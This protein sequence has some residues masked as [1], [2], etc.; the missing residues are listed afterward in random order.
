M[1]NIVFN[2]LF[3]SLSH[4]ILC[5]LFT[6]FSM[7]PFFGYSTSNEIQIVYM[8]CTMYNV[9]AVHTFGFLA[10]NLLTEHTF[11]NFD[12]L[13]GIFELKFC[14]LQTANCKLKVHC[15]LLIAEK[16][17]EGKLLQSFRNEVGQLF[18][19]DNCG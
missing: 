13:F 15:Y 6:V 9:H 10:L 11:T 12:W 18:C 16:K 19:F 8:T 3:L 5:L 4:H 2:W 14:M 7:L 1:V 17:T